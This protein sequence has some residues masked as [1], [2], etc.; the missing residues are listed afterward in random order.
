MTDIPARLVDA[1]AGRYTIE[2]QLGEGGMATVYLADDVKHGRKVAIKV[3][4]PELSAILGGERFLNEMRVTANLQHPSILPLYDSGDADGLLY[5]V[6]P[7]VEG[8][9]LRDRMDRDGQMG[10]E[11]TLAIAEDVAAALQFAHE[12][13][14]VHRD[15]KPANILLQG[16]K[17]LVADFGIAIAIRSAGGERITQTGLSLGT[18]HYMSPEQATGDRELDARSDVYSLGAMVYE[19]QS[20]LRTSM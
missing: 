1:L 12:H 13:G 18:P 5:Y 15:I 3:L 9:S 16:G 14:V 7:F 6:M 4:K 19:M 17:P 8:D 11:E 10:L 20:P 2:R